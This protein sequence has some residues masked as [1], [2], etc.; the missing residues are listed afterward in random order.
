MSIR[1][2]NAIEENR[3]YLVPTVAWLSNVDRVCVSRAGALSMDHQNPSAEGSE[4]S[5]VSGRQNRFR[6][7]Q[8][9]EYNWMEH[10][11]SSH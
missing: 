5:K 10:S 7:T 8:F 11:L 9:C 2:D 3:T 4:G 1:V 6:C